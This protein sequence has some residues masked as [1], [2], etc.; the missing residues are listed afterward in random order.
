MSIF[1][2]L[3]GKKNRVSGTQSNDLNE[4][5]SGT[6][7]NDLNERVQ[8]AQDVKQGEKDARSSSV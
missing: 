4:K 6:Q 8:A 3:F 2:R 1:Q 7:G 5:V